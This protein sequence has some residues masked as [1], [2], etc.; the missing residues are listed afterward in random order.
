MVR[1]AMLVRPAHDDE[2]EISICRL[3]FLTHEMNLRQNK[4]RRFFGENQLFF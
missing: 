3:T 4:N 2:R 1:S